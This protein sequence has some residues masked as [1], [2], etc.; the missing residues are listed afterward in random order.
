M[1]PRLA[2]AYTKDKPRFKCALFKSFD[3]ACTNLLRNWKSKDEVTAYDD[4]VD[5]YCQP[6]V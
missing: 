4:E 3:Q 5:V 1:L 6:N 2:V